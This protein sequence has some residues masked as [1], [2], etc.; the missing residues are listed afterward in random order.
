MKTKIALVT[1]GSRGL[2][3]NMAIRLAEA[4]HDVVITYNSNKDAADEV[5]E[6]IQ[7][8][9]Q[10]ASVMQLNVGNWK[11][12]ED[13]SQNFQQTLKNDFDAHSFDFLV[14]NAGHGFLAPVA[15]TSPEAFNELLDVHFRGVFFLTQKLIP[16]L[17]DGGRIINISSGLTRFTFPGYSAYAAMKGAVEVFT[18]YLAKELGDRKITANILAP[19]AIKTDFGGGAVRDN[20]EVDGMISSL[21]ALGRSGEA[22]DIGG[23]VAFLCSEDAYWINGQRIEASGGVFL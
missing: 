4:G 21:T 3:K 20:P 18:R 16:V 11:Q 22:S 9:G 12:M 10:N 8:M 15:E 5:A 1:G 17:N 2:G 13:F 19:G 14:N 7:T 6:Q 23:I